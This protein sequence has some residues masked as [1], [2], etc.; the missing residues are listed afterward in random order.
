MTYPTTWLF[1]V[2]LKIPDLFNAYAKP[3][4]SAIRNR[5]ESWIIEQGREP[6]VDSVTA[7]QVRKLFNIDSGFRG[8]CW[9]I[10]EA[11]WVIPTS[12][13]LI[14]L[15]ISNPAV[16][17][18][19]E[20]VKNGK[21]YLRDRA[22]P[23]GGWNVGNPWMLGKQLPPTPDATSFALMSW[24]VLLGASDFGSTDELQKAITLL[25][26]FVT[27]SNS[28]QTIV[29]GTLAVRLFDEN[30]ASLALMING[31]S[32]QFGTDKTSRKT[33]KGQ[34]PI[35]GGWANSAYTTA[36]AALALSDTRY[37]IQPG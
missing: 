35:S 3:E 34:D 21:E 9:G 18:Q 27:N 33:A 17:N 19:S 1:N 12:F 6:V 26:D 32:R 28:D 13:A 29:L 22:C 14:A 11:S 4:D 25:S 15:V 30:A 16:M 31:V 20:V 23:V 36:F 8:W 5:A 7:S 24:R 37:F 10:G 2:M